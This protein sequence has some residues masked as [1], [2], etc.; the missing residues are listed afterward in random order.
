MI[1]KKNQVRVFPSLGY[2]PNV[3]AMETP[4][5]ERGLGVDVPIP[6]TP[7]EGQEA[8]EERMV[9]VGVEDG[10]G[11]ELIG[12]ELVIHRATQPTDP[13]NLEGL[14]VQSAAA[15][16]ALVTPVRPSRISPSASTMAVEVMD[17]A[18]LGGSHQRFP[19][20]PPVSYGPVVGSQGVQDTTPLFTQDQLRR[21]HDLQ[22]QAPYLYQ[23]RSGKGIGDG[24][25]QRPS[26]L[27]IEGV[28]ANSFQAQRSG[29]ALASSSRVEATP[30]D[31]P[32]LQRYRDQ[33]LEESRRM[34]ERNIRFRD[35][36]RVWMDEN[37]RLRAENA[38]LR[39]RLTLTDEQAVRSEVYQTPD[40]GDDE[41]T[42]AVVTNDEVPRN[43]RVPENDEVPKNVMGL[44]FDEAVKNNEVPKPIDV[45]KFKNVPD[46][47]FETQSK[48]GKNYGAASSSSGGARDPTLELLA[49]MMEGMTN[50]QQQIINNKDKEGDSESV[51]GQQELPPLAP[52]TAATGLVDLSDWLAVIEPIMSDLSATSGS[53]W[54]MLVKEASSWYAEHLRLQPLD[55]VTHDPTP[56]SDLTQP[57]WGRLERRASTMLLSAIPQGL[58]E[59]LVA[60]KRLSALKIVCQL[61]ILY[62]P[63][64]LGEKELIL[65]QLE[66]PPE[67][68]TVAEAVQGL[69]RWFR[70]KGRASELHVQ[71][72]DAFLLLKGLNRLTK[73]PL[74]QHRDLSF[75]ISLA[76]STLQVDS[77]PTQRSIT[78]FALH[79]LAEF[80]QVVHLESHGC[81]KPAGNP[82]R[83]KNMKVKKLEEEGERGD[84]GQRRNYDGRERDPPKCRFFLTKEGCRKGKSCGFSHDLKDDLRRC[85]LCGC[86]DH[87]ANECPRKGL[88]K[89]QSTSPPNASRAE[90]QEES[91][92]Q[93]NVDGKNED[94]EKALNQTSNPTVQGLLEEATKVLKSI[95]TTSSTGVVG[96][97][98]TGPATQR[99]EMMANLQKQLDQLRTSSPTAR[100][101]RL[102]RMEISSTLGLLDSGATHPLRKLQT[103]E[104]PS[105]LR[106]VE[107]TLADGVKKLLYM[108]PTGVMVTLVEDVEP[109]VPMGLLTTV[110]DCSIKWKGE[111]II[112]DHPKR[113]R[114]AVDYKDGCP[115]VSK[116]VA[117]ELISEIEE[118]RN[119]MELKRLSFEG[120]DEWIRSLVQ[121][122][123]VLRELPTH[124]KNALMVKVGDWRDLPMNKRQRK[125]SQKSG[126]M[127]HLYSGGQDGYTLKKAMDQ[128]GGQSER[129]LELDVIRGEG[130]NL[131]EEKPFSGLLRAAVEG[132]IEALVGGP[133]CRTRSVLR[134]Y[135]IPDQ[136]EYPKPVRSWK[137]NQHY[138]LEELSDEERKKVQEDDILLWRLIFLYMV[139]TYFRDAQGVQQKVGFAMEHPASPRDYMP[140]CVSIW[141][142]E[143]WK[144]IKD[145]F[146]LEELTLRQGRYGGEATKPTTFANNLG[147]EPPTPWT[148]KVTMKAGRGEG[149]SKR[150]ARWAPGVMKMVAGALNR[151]VQEGK[152]SLKAMTWEDHLK[153]N[154]IPFRRDCKIC[155]E[156]QQRQHPHR[157]CQHPLCGV[158]SLDTTG[159]FH[160]AKDVEGN[161]KYILV[162]T[163]TWLVPQDSPL[164]E[165]EDQPPLQE[166]PPELE[167]L[168]REVEKEKEDEAPDEEQHQPELPHQDEAQI[169]GEKEEE[170]PPPPEGFKV[171]VFRMALPM[172]S[173]HSSEVTQTAM[174]FI[175]R[176]RADGFFISRVHTDGGREFLGQFRQWLATRGILHTRTPGDDPRANG[177]AEVAVQSVKTMIRRV[178]IQAGATSE[179]WPWAVRYVNELLRNFRITTPLEFPGFL[180]VVHT[181]KRTWKNQQFEAV[182]S[183]VKYL[184]PAWHEHGHFIQRENERPSVTR[185]VL[186]RLHEPTTEAHWIALEKEVEDALTLRRRIRG[187]SAIRSLE[188]DTSDQGEEVRKQVIEKVIKDEMDRLVMDD[189][190]ASLLELPI[191]NKLKKVAMEES[192]N[193]EVL[194]T[195]VISPKEVAANLDDWEAA[196]KDE[197]QS[198]LEDKEAL[199][200]VTKKEA[201]I[202][203]KDQ[204]AK[205]RTLEVI[206]S[207]LVFTRKPAPPPKNYKN[208]MRW[209]VCGNYEVKKEHE[210][211]YSGGADSTAFRLMMAISAQH[212]WCGGSVDIKTAFLNAY[213]NY[214]QEDDLVLIKPPHFLIEKNYV[215]KDVTYLPLKAVYGFRRSPRLWSQQ[216]DLELASC[217]IVVEEAGRKKR[218]SLTSLQSEPNLWR[219]SE[220]ESEMNTSPALEGLL[221]TYVDDIFVTGSEK[222]VKAVLEMISLMWTTSPAEQVSQRPIRFLG[223]EIS[224]VWNSSTS[225]EDWYVNQESYIKE[226]INKQ[227]QVKMK[228]IPITKDHASLSVPEAPPTAETVKT[229]QK[230]LLPPKGVWLQHLGLAHV[231]LPSIMMMM[232]MMMMMLTPAP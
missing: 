217:E 113:G 74:E 212:Q 204:K 211:T 145:E 139:A 72:P 21:L 57:R 223:M 172:A 73:K 197:I 66:S 124:I 201:E 75:R 180:E 67:A 96:G 8:I 68:T 41:A 181:R 37:E 83:L 99:D 191:L 120:E 19:T 58:R 45:A 157:R 188:V 127:V 95:S 151:H 122:H 146:E 202:L 165:P 61:M 119:G 162:G 203:M 155:Q 28:E 63:G 106:Q 110:L 215:E 30:M 190:G 116:E 134:H 158:L 117:M 216:R 225:S 98:S 109:I 213:I 221:M 227:E 32:L 147:L 153:H 27:P 87:F 65:R 198:L 39:F 80:E 29:R 36:N 149:D 183:Q 200:P 138:G 136:E 232:M 107:V 131:L 161:A 3:L 141:D 88:E 210:E 25:K 46:E 23:K 195:K 206:P 43:V 128:C 81:R 148:S 118:K 4:N 193:D 16:T 90:V 15:V 103:S 185:Y 143:D 26:F 104:D 222:L 42:G 196:I 112:V 50:L 76:R 77:T 209:V 54:T 219:I 48:H 163:I 156:A 52:W 231:M 220:K 123:P 207:K 69:R 199:R 192:L 224:K 2:E 64:G 114:L 182:M 228:K 208:K 53:W 125:R 173:K 133:N 178:M 142:Q 49:K 177:R 150:L 12:Q 170:R 105:R 70:W 144:K 62:Q 175:L 47:T 78:S 11:L 137:K 184:C 84:R 56:S 38:A 86:P 79:L 126:L 194:Q 92:Q 93:E 60:S 171:Q 205:G 59:E 167:D 10:R 129:L 24:E 33:L 132:K 130:H 168:L 169:E 40:H 108:T 85:Y 51:R 154:H 97:G 174:E 135:P 160:P 226:L 5:G 9:E 35:E 214:E 7:L 176:L 218:L 230:R 111:N 6:P 14:Q 189:L 71:E 187:K 31:L 166:E 152:A 159:P 18:G 102:S 44:Q 13:T 179:W 115:V 140:E 1:K 121:T 89:N 229:A 17:G 164:Q 22:Q 91:S 82:D 34:E 20:G 186:R 101:L 55:R 94:K 100:A